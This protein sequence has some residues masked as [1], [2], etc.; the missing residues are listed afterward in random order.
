LSWRSARCCYRA[1]PIDEQLEQKLQNVK[2]GLIEK[3][4][5][6]PSGPLYWLAINSGTF[7]TIPGDFASFMQGKVM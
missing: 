2:A 1:D 5:D 3:A 4:E 6:R 7:T